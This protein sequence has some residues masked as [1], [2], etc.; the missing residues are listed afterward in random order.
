MIQCHTKQF[1]SGTAVRSCAMFTPG[2][3]YLKNYAKLTDIFVH[4]HVYLK[5][6]CNDVSQ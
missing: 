1:L 3:R 6:R 5:N 4:K 2:Y